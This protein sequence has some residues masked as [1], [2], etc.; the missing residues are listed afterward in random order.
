MIIVSTTSMAERDSVLTA[1]LLALSSH[2]DFTICL[3]GKVTDERVSGVRS[4]RP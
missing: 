3:L 2:S 1:F 4:T